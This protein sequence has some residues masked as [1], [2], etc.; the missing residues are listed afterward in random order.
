MKIIVQGPHIRSLMLVMSV[1]NTSYKR[2]PP[3]CFVILLCR[4]RVLWEALS[5]HQGGPV[6]SLPD[7]GRV[8]PHATRNQGLIESRLRALG[9]IE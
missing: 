9:Y 4:G 2:L 8:E 5:D 6:Q 7:V 3:T 1:R